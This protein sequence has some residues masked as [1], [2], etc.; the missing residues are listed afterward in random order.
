M[1]INKLLEAFKGGVKGK[2]KKISDYLSGVFNAN[3]QPKPTPTPQPGYKYVEGSPIQ[4]REGSELLQKGS[5]KQGD[6]VPM[7]P[8]R[9]TAQKP[10]ASPAPQRTP[11]PSTGRRLTIPQQYSGMIRSASK[12]YNVPYPFLASVLQHESMSWNPN[13]ISGGIKS[14]KGAMGIAQF[15]PDTAG[16]IQNENMYGKFDPYKPEEAIPAAA[17]YLNYLKNSLKTPD[18]YGAAAAY[19]AGPG[20]YR[21]HEG[22]L[23]DFPETKLY[24]E[25][26]EELVGSYA[27]PDYTQPGTIAKTK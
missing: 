4:A 20:N 16:W 25:I 8:T 17:Y 15:M 21:K 23:S 6:K 19:N 13:V 24:L 2:T 27:E 14:P 10:T 18:W 11:A 22:D 12:K 7:P 5:F 26:V 1:D 3:D 9:R